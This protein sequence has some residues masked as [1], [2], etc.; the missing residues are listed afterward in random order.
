MTQLEM[1]TGEDRLSYSSAR[2]LQGCEQKY[3]YYKVGKVDKDS[4]VE[5]TTTA[6]AVGSSFHKVLEDYKH[7]GLFVHKTDTRNKLIRKALEKCVQEEGLPETDINLVHAMLIVYLRGRKSEGF[8]TIACEYVIEH[9]KVI[10]YI[11]LIE[12]DPDGG[13][14]ISDM[15]TAKSFWSTLTARLPQ[16][17][18]LNLYAKFAPVVAE[19]LQLDIDKFKGCRYLVTTKSSAKKR[20]LEDDIEFITRLCS[21]LIKS[22]TIEVPKEKL[23]P[24]SVFDEHMSLQNRAV[25]LKNGEAPN[26]NFGY[27]ETYFKPC[28]YWSRCHGE[29]FTDMK[30][31]LKVS[32]YK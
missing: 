9:P 6:F 7:E 30:E 31:G 1:F 8:K 29:N 12:E 21:G 26:R 16:D 3:W 18:Q 22:Y 11:D 28:D 13:W 24:D 14:W 10:G 2:L 20:Q 17:R 27:C 15:K 19:D 5:D 25:E 4:D 23:N 32:E